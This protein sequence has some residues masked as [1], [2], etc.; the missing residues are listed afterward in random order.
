MLSYP[1][2]QLHF[3]RAL[4]CRQAPVRF[5]KATKLPRCLNPCCS[6]HTKPETYTASGQL[7][8]KKPSRMRTPDCK[9]LFFLKNHITSWCQSSEKRW[10]KRNW[11]YFIRHH[12]SFLLGY[13]PKEGVVW[14]YRCFWRA[15]IGVIIISGTLRCLWIAWSRY[16]ELSCGLVIEL[17]GASEAHPVA[18]RWCRWL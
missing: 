8:N 18:G 13:K 5:I 7:Y 11:S 9:L 6:A 17:C 3:Q 16:Q 2:E 15:T 1:S 14:N 4:R 10:M 12:A